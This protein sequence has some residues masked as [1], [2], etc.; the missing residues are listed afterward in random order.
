[1]YGRNHAIGAENRRFPIRDS[2]EVVVL[3]VCALLR[4]LAQLAM[5]YVGDPVAGSPGKRVIGFKGERISRNGKPASAH[6]PEPLKPAAGLKQISSFLPMNSH[7][8]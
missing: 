4:Q 5:P 1:M 6:W 7:G 8:R 2:V 3:K